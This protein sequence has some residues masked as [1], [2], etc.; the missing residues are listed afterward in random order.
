MGRFLM[1]I[2]RNL[3]DKQAEKQRHSDLRQEITKH[4]EAAKTLA[5]Q[6]EHIDFTRMCSTNPEHA[7]KIQRVLMEKESRNI[8]A[9]LNRFERCLAGNPELPQLEREAES[10]SRLCTDLVLWQQVL[11]GR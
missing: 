4:L 3:K 7:A 10:L 5:F 2:R 8:P 11:Q 1:H 6:L 9:E